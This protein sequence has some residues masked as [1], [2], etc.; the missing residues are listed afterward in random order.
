[1]AI[2]LVPPAPGQAAGCGPRV[3]DLN[4]SANVEMFVSSPSVGL[5]GGAMVPL[6]PIFR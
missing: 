4:A 3:V 5:V 2:A 6:T 1:L